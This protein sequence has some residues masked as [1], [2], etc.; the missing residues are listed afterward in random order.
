MDVA[1]GRNADNSRIHM[2]SCHNGLNQR[3]EVTYSVTKPVYK[4]TNL[5]PRKPFFIRSRMSGGRVLF[6]ENRKIGG[7]Q[8][9]MSIRMPRYNK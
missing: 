8:H 4:S 9:P 5:R 7:N 6:W 1:G 2:W 3:F